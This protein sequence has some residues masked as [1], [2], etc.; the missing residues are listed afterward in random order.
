MGCHYNRKPQNFKNISGLAMLATERK[1]EEAVVIARDGR[2]GSIRRCSL[3][4]PAIGFL[5]QIRPCHASLKPKAEEA[6]QTAS[7]VF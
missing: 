4:V 6:V 7:E 1:A 2:E 5:Q 3:K